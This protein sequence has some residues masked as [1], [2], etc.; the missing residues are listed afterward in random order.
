VKSFL[1]L[2]VKFGRSEI[3]TVTQKRDI[4]QFLGKVCNLHNTGL[5][6]SLKRSLC[7]LDSYLRKSNIH[8]TF[9]SDHPQNQPNWNRVCNSCLDV[10]PPSAGR[11]WRAT[12]SGL[13]PRGRSRRPPPPSST[14]A[15]V[16]ANTN[17]NISKECRTTKTQKITNS[18]LLTSSHLVHENGRRRH[19]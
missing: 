18:E 1:I 5:Y 2:K 16:T 10:L 9:R 3:S 6:H 19:G 13:L 15:A 11:G 17:T 7:S 12:G 14:A 4:L 8:E